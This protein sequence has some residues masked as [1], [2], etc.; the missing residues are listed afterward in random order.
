M[1]LN[2][3]M[4]PNPGKTYT[5]IVDIN[6]FSGISIYIFSF[7]CLQ[8]QVTRPCV[9]CVS[10]NCE[11]EQQMTVYMRDGKFYQCLE[12]DYIWHYLLYLQCYIFL[13]LANLQINAFSICT[14]FFYPN[15]LI[16]KR[17]DFLFF[18]TISS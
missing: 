15:F 17:W 1:F 16:K 12:V 5:Y 11:L 10:G 13:D 6:L 2:W 9:V 18:L 4:I 8:F 7:L 3:L 14:T